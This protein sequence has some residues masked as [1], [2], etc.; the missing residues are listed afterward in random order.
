VGD[1]STSTSTPASTSSEGHQHSSS[2][3][4]RSNKPRSRVRLWAFRFVAVLLGLSVFAVVEML[5]VL[6]EW[7]KPTDYPD[8]YVGFSDGHPLFVRDERGEQFVIP[9]SRLGFF[10]PESFPVRKEPDAFRIF[11]FGGST[12]QGRPYSTPTSFPTWLQ[13]SLQAGDSR[14]TWEV[15]NCGGVSYASYRLAPI[16]KECLRYEPDL[17]IICTGH[18]EFLEERTYEHIKHAPPVIAKPSRFLSRLRSVT[19]LRAA[20]NRLNGETDAV[21]ENRPTLKSE[22]DALLDYKNG[23]RPYQWDGEWRKGVVEHFEF[24]LRRM[25][26]LASAVDVP[27]VLVLPPSNLRDT[28]PFKS[29]STSGLSAEERARRRSFVRRAHSQEGQ[30]LQHRI[31]LL[32][33]A[34][35]IDGRHAGLRYEL[36]RCYDAL[37]QRTGDAE[38]LTKARAAYVRA[39]DLDVCPLRMITS[40]EEALRRVA[41]EWETPLLDAHALLEADCPGGILDNTL[42]VDHIHPSPNVGHP[43]IAHALAQRLRKHGWF[44]PSADWKSKRKAAFAEHRRGL[45][46]IYYERGKKT[47]EALRMWT[48]GRA[49]GPPIETR[50]K[51]P[52]GKRANE[53]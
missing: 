35:D 40:L 51:G 10:K 48:Q 4:K 44:Q 41:R 25:I 21:P 24:N 11:C 49:D 12:V 26:A 19:L 45:S 3:T 42:L 17:F 47:L 22:V 18:N 27:V 50:Q 33:Q 36:G 1:F 31:A 46:D 53:R 29:E 9:E 52:Y 15:V 39:R 38:W 5:C 14:R 30:H 2:R 16:V 23:L 8:P 34:V 7:G 6:F 28:P 13:L 20:V 37:W 43:R 32:E